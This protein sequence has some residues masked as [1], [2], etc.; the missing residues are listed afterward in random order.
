MELGAGEEEV[1]GVVGIEVDMAGRVSFWELG[2]YRV[3]S[4]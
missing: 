1:G 4:R 3:C 2:A